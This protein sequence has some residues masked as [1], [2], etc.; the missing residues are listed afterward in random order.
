M[1]R[2]TIAVVF[3][4]VVAG[5]YVGSARADSSALDNWFLRA[6]EYDA[7]G[8]AHAMARP[9]FICGKA[10]DSMGCHFKRAA[11]PIVFY[12][13]WELRYYDQTHHIGFAQATTDQESYAL[14]Q[15]PPPPVSVPN[16]DLSQ[17]STGRGLRIGSPYAQVLHT[18]GPPA[19]H[20][21][22]FATLYAA[23]FPSTDPLTGRRDMLNEIVTLVIDN[24]RVSSISISIDLH[25]TS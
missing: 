9:D 17:V 7:N 20:G 4:L 18:Y 22:R 8:T 16:A 24:G 13:V 23:T 2:R 19:L 11:R 6:T 14:F 3:F 1:M 21:Q 25:P 10:F 15:A 12:G 5:M